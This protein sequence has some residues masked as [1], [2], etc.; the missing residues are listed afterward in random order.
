MDFSLHIF[1]VSHQEKTKNNS[2]GSGVFFSLTRLI[3]F[4][5]IESCRFWFVTSQGLWEFKKSKTFLFH[6]Y[7]VP[8]T[9]TIVMFNLSLKLN[10]LLPPF[11]VNA[12]YGNR[13]HVNSLEGC[14]ATTTPTMLR[15]ITI[16]EM[17]FRLFKL[18]FFLTNILSVTSKR[19]HNYSLRSGVVFSLIRLICFSLIES[20]RFWFVTS[21]G[22]GDSKRDMNSLFHE[23]FVLLTHTIVMFNLSL[24]LNTFLPVVWVY[25]SYLNRTHVN[26][27][28]GV[29]ATTTPTMLRR[30]TIEEMNVRTFKLGFF[31]THFPSVTSRK[32]Q[33]NSM[34]SGVNFSLTRPICSHSSKAVVVSGFLNLKVNG[35][36]KNDKNL[37][38][39]DILSL[40][41]TQ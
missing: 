25:A 7:F 34:R 29:Y 39:H 37:L 11:W 41:R 31:L 4:S 24:K 17:N 38:F 33:N 23:Y 35:N 3:R 9:H 32:N 16:E 6:E 14:Y 8:V 20:C 19:N 1:R 12:S 2:L 18:G 30:L 26:S 10:I 40:W 21:Q 27:L 36:L 22:F 13:T 5:L 28:E 15:R